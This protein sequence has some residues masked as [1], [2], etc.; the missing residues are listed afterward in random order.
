MWWPIF[1]HHIPTMN[2]VAVNLQTLNLDGPGRSPSRF[3]ALRRVLCYILIVL[4]VLGAALSFAIADLYFAYN[5]ESCQNIP[6]PAAG[7]S[8]TLGTWLKVDGYGVVIYT[9]LLLLAKLANYC[10]CSFS[11]RPLEML[12]NLFFTAWIIVGAVMF[13]HFLEPSELC[14]TSLSNYMWARLIV[15]CI[16]SAAYLCCGR[17]NAREMHTPRW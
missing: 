16:S 6:R 4:A 10:I 14:S 7:I 13:W 8:F 17:E 3:A 2:D 5:L 9:A 11:T 1:T 12:C 15:G